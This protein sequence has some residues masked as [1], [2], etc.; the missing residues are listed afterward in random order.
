[1]G[2]TQLFYR[3]PAEFASGDSEVPANGAI[4][5]AIT[6]FNRELPG[7]SAAESVSSKDCAQLIQGLL[8]E[9]YE[10]NT[11]E[12]LAGSPLVQKL[13]YLARPLLRVPVR[14]QLQKISL[15]DWKS[16]AFPHWP[17]DRTV[18]AIHEQMLLAKMRNHGIARMPFIWFWP[19]GHQAAFVM[20][21]DVETKAGLDFCPTLMNWDDA[22]GIKA[23]FQVVPEER[24]HATERDLREM[25]NR[26]F[27][28]NVHDL[29]HDGL[30][31]KS[32]E[33]FLSRVGKINDCG[34]RFGARG[35][36]AG[37]LYRNQE[38]F[39]SLNFQYD[40]S[41]PNVAH[42]D[43]QRGG[44]CTIFPYFIG[45]IL[46]LPVTMIQDYSLFHILN[47]YSI[48]IWQQQ[49]DIIRQH[50]GLAE[51]ITHP[52]YL[53]SAKAQ[54]TYQALLAHVTAERNRRNLW[55]ALPGEVNDWWRQ[56][57]RMDLRCV[58]G[59]WE[60]HG[61]GSSRARIAYAERDGD[62]LRY[63]VDEQHRLAHVPAV[64]H[65]PRGAQRRRGARR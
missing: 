53:M 18:D 47:D 38:W 34:V 48:S 4:A 5:D 10:R 13:Y 7:L 9:A 31:F 35:F 55:V 60:I 2:K 12:G 24:Y 14:R 41:V 21:H 50:H 19:D 46:E 40:M 43:P 42:L 3:H 54:N 17:V 20:T 51:V 57:S 52:D 11:Y 49:L 61:E 22:F 16:R 8:S 27:E 65:Q 45:N 23:A 44:C 29:N 32:R 59:T 63:S 37:A 26:G 36:R 1:M 64:R 62:Q 33:Q 6:A 58:E 15:R 25:Q 56:R 30:L 39:G 28:V